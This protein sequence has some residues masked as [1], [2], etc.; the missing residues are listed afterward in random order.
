MEFLQ[1]NWIWFV[2]IGLVVWMM[3]SGGGCCG[4]GKHGWGKREYE[5]HQH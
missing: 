5:S 4:S 3:V 2:V 1:S